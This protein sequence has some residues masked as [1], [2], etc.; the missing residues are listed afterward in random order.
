MSIGLKLRLWKGEI[1]LLLQERKSVAKF[2]G[3]VGSDRSLNDTLTANCKP[4]LR[5]IF[6]IHLYHLNYLHLAK[7]CVKNFPEARF[8]ISVRDEEAKKR[9]TL[10][11]NGRKHESEI[12]VQVVGNGG[13]NFGPILNEFSSVIS[14]AEIL[15]HL[16]SKA[17]NSSLLR[18]M[19]SRNLWGSLGLSRKKIMQIF[20]QFNDPKLGMVSPFSVRWMPK[21]FTWYGNLN[22]ARR[23]FPNLSESYAENK[24]IYFPV[25]GMFMVRIDAIRSI[26]QNESLATSLL[27]ENHDQISFAAGK[28][29]EHMLER[30]IGLVMFETHQEHLVYL[31]DTKNFMRSDKFLGAFNEIF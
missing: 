21:D 31:C 16:H 29:P 19:W 6:H 14:K 26:L 18:M 23:F 15:I 20:L 12:L 5:V 2:N 9:V 3:L 1:H 27:S 4:D 7:K 8:V 30:L 24:S 28:A 13:R 22:Q 11:L 10:K 17:W 25:G